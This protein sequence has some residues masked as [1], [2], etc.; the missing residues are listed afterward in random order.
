MPA[1]RRLYMREY[2]MKRRKKLDTKVLCV[3]LFG[4]EEHQILEM[5]RDNAEKQE[6]TIRDLVVTSLREACAH[7]R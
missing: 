7:E 4:P 5:L 6:T 2:Q 1:D 3:E